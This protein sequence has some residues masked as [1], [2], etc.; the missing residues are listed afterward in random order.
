MWEIYKSGSTRGEWAAP[1]GV[2]HSPTLPFICGPTS[3][4][5]WVWISVYQRVSAAFIPLLSF[6]CPI[7]ARCEQSS[8]IFGCGHRPR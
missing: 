4:S 7:R 5:S 3:C 2:T 1:C 8:F 6:R